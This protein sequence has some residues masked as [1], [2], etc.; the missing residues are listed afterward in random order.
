M[1]LDNARYQHGALVMQ[2][3]ATLNIRLQFLPSYSPNLNLIERLWQFIKRDVLCFQTP[4]GL[5]PTTGV[6]IVKGMR[7]LRKTPG[8]LQKLSWMK[9]GMRC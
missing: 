9:H 4:G 5:G 7:I 8:D 1:V 2:L 3:A 6:D